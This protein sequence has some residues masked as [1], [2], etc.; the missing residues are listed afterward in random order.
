MF[1]SIRAFALERLEADGEA[2][3]VRAR[4]TEVFAE[5]AQAGGDRMRSPDQPIWLERLDAD[6]ENLHAAVAYALAAGDADLALRLC[7]GMWRFW[8]TRGHLSVGRRF[9]EEAVAAAG[10][11]PDELLVRALMAAGILA[12]EAGDQE[13]GTQHMTAALELS[14]E[15]GYERGILRASTNL[16]TLALYEGRVAESV[17][18]YAEALEW[19]AREGDPWSTNLLTHNLASAYEALGDLDRSLELLRE[20]LPGA[21]ELGDPA[22]LSTVLRTLGRIL[23]QEGR[24][25]QEALAM[26]RESLVIAHELGERPGI[27]ECLESIAGAA[28]RVGDLDTS[29][30]LMGAAG[31]RP[32]GRR[33][34]APCRR[35]AVGARGL[36]R[37]AGRAGRGRVR[38]RRG[39]RP[40]SRDRRGDLA[41]DRRRGLNAR[42][43]PSG[44]PRG[45]GASRARTD[46]LR[47]AM[48]ALSQLSYSPK[49]VL[50]REVYRG[51]LDCWRRARDAGEIALDPP[52]HRSAAR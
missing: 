32:G 2:D 49:L 5:L 29:A 28:E 27:V 18:R 6:H 37:A 15:L 34:G 22:H 16:G 1:E 19:A 14:R 51:A 30:L 35:G 20:A 43:R 48:A 41:R 11:T 21:R 33:V 8:L 25:D 31:G 3:A 47:H 26:L 40:A 12:G 36:Q 13:R 23:L 46:D 52:L 39:P 44:R 4:F 17:E 24:D 50:A 45:S 7:D 9:A 42:G 38:G 10:A